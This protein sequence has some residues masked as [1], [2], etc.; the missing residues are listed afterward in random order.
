MLEPV[1]I[2]YKKIK[3]KQDKILRSEWSNLQY[4]LHKAYLSAGLKRECMTSEPIRIKCYD[5][6]HMQ[7]VSYT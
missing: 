1:I 3:I 5:K 2:N 7:D 4:H 6:Q